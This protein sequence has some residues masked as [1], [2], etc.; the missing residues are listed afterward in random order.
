[1]A[2]L[3]W[4]LF[5]FFIGNADAHLKNLSFLWGE[6]GWELA[7]HYDLLS[8]A[9]YRAPDW[10]IETLVFPMGSATR[11]AD[12]TKAEIGAFGQSI[13]VPAALTLRELE[14]LAKELW[15]E[16][17]AQLQ[18]YVQ[19]IT[20]EVDPGEARLLRQIVYGPITDALAWASRWSRS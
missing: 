14:R 18:A 12:V 5:N 17:Q 1:L 20:H 4:Q 9:V 10:G 13:G 3:R 11:F 19:G 8:T 6:K 2:L 7:P 16:A 15:R